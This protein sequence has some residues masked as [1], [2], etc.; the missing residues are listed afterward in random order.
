MDLVDEQHVIRLKVGQQRGEVAGA[1]QHGAGSVA[2]IPPH[3]ARD[4]LCQ[5]GLAQARR[6]KQQHMIERFFAPLCRFYEYFQLPAYLFLPDIFFELLGAQRT[7]HH[8]FM[9][10]GWRGRNQARFC[11]KVIAMDHD[12]DKSLRAW[13][14]PSETLLSLGNCLA[15]QSAS[16]SL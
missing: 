15:A 4:D 1:L 6:A 7:L 2:Q 14:M 10:R 13:R 12:L 3:L 5:R 9:L 11:G 8:L 16:L